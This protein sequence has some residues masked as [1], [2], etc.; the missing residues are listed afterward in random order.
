MI[1]SRSIQVAANGIIL[2]FFFY[3]WVIFY[4]CNEH[5]GAYIFS[6]SNDG[7]LWIYAN[8]CDCLITWSLT[9][10]LRDLH[11]VLHSGCANLQQCRTVP[12]SPCPLH[13][14]FFNGRWWWPFWPRV[15]WYLIAVLICISLIIT[16]VKHHFMCLFMYVFY[17]EIV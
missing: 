2:F 10:C 9:F 5:W 16:D 8:E 6:F 15:R 14:L 13:H 11:T 17:E 1:I 12:F 3:G 4:S 7:F